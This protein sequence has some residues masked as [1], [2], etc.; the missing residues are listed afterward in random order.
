MPDN[1]YPQPEPDEIRLTEILRALADPGRVK[2]LQVLADGEYHACT[3]E[4][5]GL[6]LTKSTLSHHF[7]ALREAGLTTVRIDGRHHSI[8]LRRDDIESRF[9]GLIGSLTSE[10]AVA[11]VIAASAAT[12]ARR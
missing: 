2:M 11:D 5:Y 9:P 4:E 10:T 8:A 7:K 12:A 1:P 6:D 3:V